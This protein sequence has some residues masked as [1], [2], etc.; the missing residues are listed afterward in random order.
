AAAA[1][2]GFLANRSYFIVF[3]ADAATSVVYG[4]IALFALPHGLRTY[5]KEERRVEAVR[6]AFRDP[7]VVTFLAAAM[8]AAAVDFQMG[9]TFALH[10]TQEG[11]SAA[12]YGMLL[13]I[14][15]VMIVVF[16]LLIT[17]FVQRLDPRPVLAAG[18]L[19]NGIGFALT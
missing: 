13:S 14:N 1:P 7:R 5:S 19:L 3:A 17:A 11:F 2:A 10:V 9:S 6:T 15:G 18:Y 12:T 16:E 8:L 4:I